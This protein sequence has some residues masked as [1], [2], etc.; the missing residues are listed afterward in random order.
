M[1]AASNRRND[2]K[3][4]RIIQAAIAVFAEKGFFHAKVS[5][6]ARRAGVAD[7]TIYL[8]FKNKEDILIS[9]FE[10]KMEEVITDMKE[11]LSGES[12]AITKLKRF[13]H[14]HLLLVER[15]PDLAE[16][17]HIELRQSNKF[18]KAYVPVKFFEYLDLLS[19][20]IVEGQRAGQIRKDVVPQIARRAIFGALDEI[21]LRWVVARRAARTEEGERYSELQHPY[22]LEVTAEQVATLL[23]QGL[24]ECEVKS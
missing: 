2:D 21:S 8:Y 6:I 23:I 20:L 7:G 16:V 24:T 17:F 12:D 1:K 13:V 9:I 5:Q 18:M 3:H 14:H 10:E 4:E 15:D 11:V 19:D 22:S